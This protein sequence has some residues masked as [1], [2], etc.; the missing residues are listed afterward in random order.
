MEVAEN[1]VLTSLSWRV[2]R[3]ASS[4]AHSYLLT[5]SHRPTAGMAVARSQPPP[6]WQALGVCPVPRPA[7][8]FARSY[9][10]RAPVGQGPSGHDWLAT[11]LPLF[12]LVWTAACY[13]HG[14][15]AWAGLCLI[16][17]NH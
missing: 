16:H 17:H 5:T 3:P 8:S 10:H 12:F 15:G 13:W 9:T 2:P 4:L 1:L 14:V 6:S 11:I 7:G